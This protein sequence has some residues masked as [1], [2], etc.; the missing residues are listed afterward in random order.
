MT[1]ENNSSKIPTLYGWA[2]GMQTFEKLDVFYKKVLPDEL[3][4]PIFKHIVY[5]VNFINKICN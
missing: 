2:G 4:E 3:L 1:D 5:A